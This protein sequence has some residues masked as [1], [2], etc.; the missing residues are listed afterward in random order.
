MSFVDAETKYKNI[1]SKMRNV[2]NNL[3]DIPLDRLNHESYNTLSKNMRTALQKMLNGGVNKFDWDKSSAVAKLIVGSLVTMW[4]YLPEDVWMEINEIFTGLQ[5]LI[6]LKNIEL[7]DYEEAIRDEL[8]ENMAKM[9]TSREK[10]LQRHE[11]Q[12][13]MTKMRKSREKV[14]QRHE[15]RKGIKTDNSSNVNIK[16]LVDLL[17]QLVIE[18][19]GGTTS[20]GPSDEKGSTTNKEDGLRLINKIKK[21]ISNLEEEVTYYLDEGRLKAIQDRLEEEF[22]NELLLESYHVLYA[23]ICKM[24]HLMTPPQIKIYMDKLNK[25]RHDIVYLKARISVTKKT[26]EIEEQ[27]EKSMQEAYDVFPFFNHRK[28][29]RKDVEKLLSKDV[30]KKLEH[31]LETGADISNQ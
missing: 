24:C 12:E 28:N 10:V 16:L 9:R 19:E 5:D 29:F 23:Q 27:I 31:V 26:V 4:A 14:L 8:Q 21:I 30:D 7:S 20:M 6:E 22:D 1:I 25:I 3:M 11:K 13:N 15:N 17:E 18:L 2:I